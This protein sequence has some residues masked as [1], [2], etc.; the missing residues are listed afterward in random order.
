MAIDFSLYIS[1]RN[2]PYI[3]WTVIAIVCALFF[4]VANRAPKKSS[5][6]P[7]SKPRQERQRKRVSVSLD[8]LLL[9]LQDNRTAVANFLELCQSCEVFPIA[10]AGSDAKEEEVSESLEAFGAFAAGLRRHRLMFSSTCEG[11]ASMVRQLQPD[12]HLEAAPEVAEALLGKVP[13]VRLVEALPK[14][15]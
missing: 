12:L 7:S 1:K 4:L 10:L 14:A 8:G 15:Q 9:A 6:E 3:I 5:G 13:E 2:A 11:R